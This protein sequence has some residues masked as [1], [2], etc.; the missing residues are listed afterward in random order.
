MPPKP[1]T[2]TDALRDVSAALD[3]A[4]RARF[5]RIVNRLLDDVERR[6]RIGEA[7]EIKL[8]LSAVMPGLVRQASTSKVDNS[9]L[10]AEF[11]KVMQAV[12]GDGKS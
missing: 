9:E 4:T 5:N 2:R 11:D 12:R 6:L 8:L 1:E 3:E 10:R 7:A